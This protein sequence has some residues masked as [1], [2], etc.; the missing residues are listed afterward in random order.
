MTSGLF[1]AILFLLAA[2]ILFLI[3]IIRYKKGVKDV[4]SKEGEVKK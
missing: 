3:A 4:N 2:E 1:G